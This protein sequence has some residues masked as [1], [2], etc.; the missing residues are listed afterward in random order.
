MRVLWQSIV[1]LG[2]LFSAAE[3]NEQHVRKRL[4]N[5]GQNTINAKYLDL[6]S[7]RPRCPEETELPTSQEEQT[8]GRS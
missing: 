3:A 7:G 6:T 1:I 2:F 8:R 5:K 4:N